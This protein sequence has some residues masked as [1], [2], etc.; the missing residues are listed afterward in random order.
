MGGNN[1]LNVEHRSIST[2]PILHGLRGGIDKSL[3]K[4]KCA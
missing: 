1:Q 4:P 2:I 3:V